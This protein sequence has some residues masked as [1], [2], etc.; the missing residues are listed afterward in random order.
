M[1]GSK[2]ITKTG[3]RTRTRHEGMRGK[4]KTTAPLAASLSRLL[5]LVQL[6]LCCAAIKNRGQDRVAQGMVYSGWVD[7]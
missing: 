2:Y 7:L 6:L 5:Q 3:Q 1:C 4:F